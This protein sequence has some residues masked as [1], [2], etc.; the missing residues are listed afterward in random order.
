MDQ[1]PKSVFEKCFDNRS[2]LESSCTYVCR[3]LIHYQRA[4]LRLCK[5]WRWKARVLLGRKALFCR[6]VC[7][8]GKTFPNSASTSC[9]LK[10][11]FEMWNMLNFEKTWYWEPVIPYTNHTTG[12]CNKSLVLAVMQTDE[13]TYIKICAEIIHFY[14]LDDSDV[15]YC[16]LIYM[17]FWLNWKF[18][19]IW[20]DD[21][22]MKRLSLHAH[23]SAFKALKR[24]SNDN[25]FN[26]SSL[27]DA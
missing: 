8:H 20:C 27:E 13:I 12:I 15:G 6:Y 14:S 26:W 2:K 1:A 17:T 22:T 3:I 23:F 7:Y 4:R 9:S 16:A 5:I 11:L 10:R 24:D 21:N 25:T 18:E 19:N